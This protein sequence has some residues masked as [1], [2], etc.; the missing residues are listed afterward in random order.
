MNAVGSHRRHPA[1]I[2][3]LLLGLVTTGELYSLLAPRAAESAAATAGQES[4]GAKLFQANSAT[5]HGISGLG[6]K[7][8]PTLAGVGAAAV[9]FQVGT[10]RMPL[11]NPSV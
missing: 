8:G 10:G 6:D 11:D 9:D 4:S 7:T 1:A 3:L 5:C 2:L